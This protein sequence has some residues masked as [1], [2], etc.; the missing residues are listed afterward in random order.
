METEGFEGSLPMRLQPGEP[1][2]DIVAGM[3]NFGRFGGHATDVIGYAY[4]ADHHCPICAGMR[5]GVDGKG[6]VYGEDSEGNP[7]HPVFGS[8]EWWNTEEEDCQRLSCGDCHD[9]ISTAH[10]EGESDDHE[11][12]TLS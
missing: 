2:R 4:D 7:V 3:I 10:I 5:F 1:N 8:D 6:F 12:C 11:G 9:E